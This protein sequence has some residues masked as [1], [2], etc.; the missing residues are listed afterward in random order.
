MN[1]NDFPRVWPDLIP[2]LET[3][4]ARHEEAVAKMA[5]F[6]KRY[7]SVKNKVKRIEKYLVTMDEEDRT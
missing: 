5:D 7:T 1:P 3:A 4:L 2:Q 6:K